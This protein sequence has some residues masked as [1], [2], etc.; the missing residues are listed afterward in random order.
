MHNKEDGEAAGVPLFNPK[1]NKFRPRVPSSE[2]HR[3]IY[4]CLD[5]SLGFKRRGMLVNH[6][7]KVHPAKEMSSVPELNLPILR[8]Q[9]NYYCNLCRLVNPM[10]TLIL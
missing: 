6:L 3:F 8:E 7:A 10:I 4:K 2:Y 5:C 1:I 9:R